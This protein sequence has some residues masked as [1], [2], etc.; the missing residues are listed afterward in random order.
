MGG[1]SLLSFFFA[2]L[3]FQPIAELSCECMD[4]FNCGA[5]HSFANDYYVNPFQ[6]PNYGKFAKK[7]T[8]PYEDPP[9]DPDRAQPPS[10]EELLTIMA[11]PRRK[12]RGGSTLQYDA[13][14]LP[15][16]LG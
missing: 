11:K 9:M 6:P 8:I 1:L 10:T 5:L 2:I 12:G 16:A 4:Y 13:K 3:C 14:V 15:L 7:R